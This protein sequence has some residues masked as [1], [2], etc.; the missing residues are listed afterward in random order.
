VGALL[1]MPWMVKRLA[2][3]TVQLFSDFRPFLQ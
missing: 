2:L 3:F 1:L